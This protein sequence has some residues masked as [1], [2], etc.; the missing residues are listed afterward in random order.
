MRMAEPDYSKVFDAYNRLPPDIKEK[1]DDFRAQHYV[2]GSPPPEQMQK[3]LEG[4]IAKYQT[5]TKSPAATSGTSNNQRWA[6]A[7]GLAS[8]AFFLGYFV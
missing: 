1:F 2:K 3:D 6:Y 7:A 4:I 5:R 8:I